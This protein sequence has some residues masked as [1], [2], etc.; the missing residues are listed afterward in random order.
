MIVLYM[1]MSLDGFVVGPD[2]SMEEPMGRGGFRLFTC[3]TAWCAR[4]KAA[5]APPDSRPR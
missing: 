3:T 1:S 2:D 5:A 4:A